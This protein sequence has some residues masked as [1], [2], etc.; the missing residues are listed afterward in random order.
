M[1]PVKKPIEEEVMK[2]SAGGTGVCCLVGEKVARYFS[3][4]YN[5][6]RRRFWKVGR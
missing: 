1:N 3:L 4:G 6:I 5:E 2:F